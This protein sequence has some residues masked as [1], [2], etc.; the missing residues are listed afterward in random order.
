MS[1]ARLPEVTHLQF[2]VLGLLRSDERLG[3]ELRDEL[4]GHRVR[5]SAA[6]FYQMMARL[7]E[8][9]LVEGW[10]DQKVV[11]GQIIK[12]RRYRLTKAG[13]RAWAETRDFYVAS[14]AQA[15]PKKRWSDA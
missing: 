5:R 8:A 12:E 15:A 13:A 7:E 6:A 10:Y 1:K 4:A 2:L 11:E 14:L 3:R 9:G